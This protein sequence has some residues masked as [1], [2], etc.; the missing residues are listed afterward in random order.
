[1]LN[2]NNCIIQK[3]KY[4]D[5]ISSYEDKTFRPNKNI[6]IEEVD[7][8]IT[9]IKNN[10]IDKLEKYLNIVIMKKNPIRRD[11]Q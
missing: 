8:I 10:K 5:Y 3:S 4:V 9:T 1:M 2:K 7:N 6:T 11:Y